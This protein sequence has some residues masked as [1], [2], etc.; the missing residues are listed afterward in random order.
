MVTIAPSSLITLSTFPRR[1]A[2]S[3]G[4]YGADKKL[5]TITEILMLEFIMGSASAQVIAFIIVL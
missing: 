1:R 2:R 5:L 4:C 3:V